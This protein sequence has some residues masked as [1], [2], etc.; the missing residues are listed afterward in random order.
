MAKFVN[1]DHDADQDDIMLLR[2]AQKY[3]HRCAS[4]S[5]DDRRRLPPGSDLETRESAS[6]R[7]Q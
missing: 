2:I 6:L 5:L 7:D 3:V 1:H 4:V